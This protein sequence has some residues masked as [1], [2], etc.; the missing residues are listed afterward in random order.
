MSAAVDP[1]DRLGL[2]RP[3]QVRAAFHEV[4]HRERLEL[5]LAAIA[6]SEQVSD[7][8]PGV[9]DRGRRAMREPRGGEHQQEPT[10]LEHTEQLRRDRGQEGLKFAALLGIELHPDRQAAH[11]AGSARCAGASIAPPGVKTVEEVGRVGN[12]QMDA[13]GVQAGE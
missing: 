8:E 5:S 6:P 3:R 10:G 11:R 2:L 1:A 4:V 7:L 12:D 9:L 13:G